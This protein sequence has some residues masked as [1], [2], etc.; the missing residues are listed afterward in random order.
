VTKNRQSMN[1]NHS[2]KQID[3]HPQKDLFIPENQADLTQIIQHANHK[4][5]TL[6]ASGV[7]RL[8]R[9][10]GNQ[11]TMQILNKQNKIAQPHHVHQ[12]AA[13][14]NVQRV[15]DDPDYVATP[16]STGHTVPDFEYWVNSMWKEVKDKSTKE[17]VIGL[18]KDGDDSPKAGGSLDT[19]VKENVL[20]KLYSQA[21][22]QKDWVTSTQLLLDKAL[23]H[24][25]HAP[26]GSSVSTDTETIAAGF[27]G[28]W[29]DPDTVLNL[30]GGTIP[31]I[32][33]HGQDPE[34]KEEIK[35]YLKTGLGIEEWHP[36]WFDGDISQRPFIFRNVQED[37]E[38]DTTIS[39]AKS[40]IDSLDFPMIE[41]IAS[42]DITEYSPDGLPIT[43]TYVYLVGVTSG[44]NTSSMQ[45]KNKFGEG[46][47]A[48]QQLKPDDHLGYVKYK[49]VHGG[50]SRNDGYTYQA[51]FTEVLAGARRK[52]VTSQVSSILGAMPQGGSRHNPKDVQTIYQDLFNMG[53]EVGGRANSFAKKKTDEQWKNYSLVN[54]NKHIQTAPTELAKNKR[55]DKFVEG[56]RSVLPAPT[57]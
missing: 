40:A 47:I 17:T 56:V 44:F 26:K 15:Y 11:A 24:V 29:R 23:T 13:Q 18:L 12:I 21:Y 25:I 1:N 42:K 37:N 49:R 38:L 34:E 4:P 48:T 51:V 32:E 5:D 3:P 28:T 50:G 31:T 43:Y 55:L 8:Q 6:S 45:G 27:H 46:E 30:H 52:R 54:Q 22:Q 2:K 10:I 57:T 16:Y 41:S 20:N 9:T 7:M 35:D 33:R 53:A 19:D 39:V 14:G 36:F